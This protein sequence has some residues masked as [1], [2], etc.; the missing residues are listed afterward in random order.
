MR[1]IGW[2]CTPRVAGV[3]D[4]ATRDGT[5]VAGA[6][7]TN[8]SGTLTFVA[9]ETRKTVDVQVLADSHDE[10]S[11]T[12]TLALSNATGAR[13]A[14]GEAT[15]TIDNSGSILQAWIARFGRTVGKAGKREYVQV[16]RLLETFRLEEVE[17]AVGDALRLGAIGFDAVKHLVLCRIERRPPRLNLDVYPYLPRA[18]VAMTSAKS[19]MSLLSGLG[20]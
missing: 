18:R 2:S 6:D 11:E 4:Y 9:G 3:V 5:A 17:G 8:T 16:L 15:G 13:I 12:M 20:A 10:G 19:Y 7:Y 14:D 1:R